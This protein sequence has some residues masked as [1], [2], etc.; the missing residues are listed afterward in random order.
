MLCVFT[1]FVGLSG[2]ATLYQQE[3][4]EAIVASHI[5]ISNWK[6][7]YQK[8]FGVGK[9]YIREFIPI[10]DSIGQ[11]S[12]MLSIEFLEGNKSTPQEFT[13]QF[14]AQRK[15]QCPSTEFKILES[16]TD[17][18]YYQANFP[19]CMGHLKQSEL[20]RVIR[21]NDGLH[22]ISYSTK[23]DLTEADTTKWLNEF[24]QARLVKG[25]EKAIVR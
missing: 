16:D 12:K 4:L 17:N 24:K 9:G 2:C 3:P 25:R 15:S 11:W 10:N 20:T 6:V 7:G 19:E 14:M 13:D 18:I 21:G 1:I 22:R 23:G 8:Q 5:D